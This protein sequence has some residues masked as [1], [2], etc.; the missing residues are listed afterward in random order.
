MKFGVSTVV[1]DEGIGP[2]ELGRALEERG[3]ESLFVGEHTHIPVKRETPWPGGGDLAR[4]MYRT[5]DPMVVLTAAA[6]VTERLLLGAGVFQVTQRDPIVL[7]KEIA[8]LDRVS[9]GRTVVGVGAGWNREEIRNHGTDPKTRMALL[10]ERVLA[11]KALWT[12]EKAEFHGDFVDFDPV[13]SWPKP[14]QAPHPPVMVGG[15]H[16]AAVERV[17]EFGDDWGMIWLPTMV[18][19]E[20]KLADQV[21]DF[22]RRAAERG[23]GYLPVTMYQVPAEPEA[24]D[25]IMESGADRVLF[26]LPTA[27]VPETLRS[28]DTMV[29]LIG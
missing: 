22:R 6:V 17:L 29:R 3:F 23:R 18:T 12:E 24:L 16:P 1:T 28:L 2:V 13:F 10:R 14:V 5:L 15:N 27:P 26:T 21:T 20:G 11:M 4:D 25:A 8:S 9:G 7:A 19:G